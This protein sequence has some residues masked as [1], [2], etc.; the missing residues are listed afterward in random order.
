MASSDAGREGRMVDFCTPCWKPLFRTHKPSHECKTIDKIGSDHAPAAPHS[1]VME[2][3]VF[4]SFR[5]PDTRRGFADYLYFSLRDAGV[6]VFRDNE[7]LRSGDE[8]G[9][10]LCQGIL[11]SKISIPIFSE[12][13][14]SSKWCLRELAI[15]AECRRKVEQIVMPI[16]YDVTPDQVKNQTGKYKEALRR[17]ANECRQCVGQWRSALSEV[18][19]LKGWVLKDTADG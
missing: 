12:G 2:Y 17:H 3:E 1:R 7:E 15:I 11:Q 16:F 10:G 19:R 18:G 14:A 5:G 9:P 13:Y 8:I 6:R 4:L